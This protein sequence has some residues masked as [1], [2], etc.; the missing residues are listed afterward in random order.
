MRERTPPTRAERALLG[1]AGVITTIAALELLIRLGAIS[2]EALPPPTVLAKALADLAARSDFWSALAA[3]LVAWA[4]AVGAAAAVSVPAGIAIGSSARARRATEGTIELLR[5]IPSVALL[6]VAILLYGLGLEMKVLLA[7]YASVW[8]ILVNTMYGV[9]ETDR[10]MLDTA[11]SF[12]W[13]RLRILRSVTLR[14]A[15][16]SIATGLRVAAAVALIVVLTAEIL[17]ANSG[18]GELIRGYQQAGR[19]E[20]VYAGIAATGILGLLLNT[21]LSAT[22]RRLLRWT[23]EHRDA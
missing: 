5:P 11:R 10:L 6:P 13:S 23:P 3:T 8:P 12:R 16:P 19:R 9:A 14:A 2:D 1:A 22:E 7:A 20:F 4:L 15:S 18:L 17:A 21:G